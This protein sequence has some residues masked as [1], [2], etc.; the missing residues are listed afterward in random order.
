MTDAP[1]YRYAVRMACGC[2]LAWETDARLSLSEMQEAL[3]EMGDWH[4]GFVPCLAHGWSLPDRRSLT[5]RRIRHA[6]AETRLM[7]LGEE[8]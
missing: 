5:G 3:A 4:N 2:T 1:A 8:L 6:E 7:L